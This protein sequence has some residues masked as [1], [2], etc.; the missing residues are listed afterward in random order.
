MFIT[1]FFVLLDC[2]YDL[3]DISLPKYNFRPGHSPNYSELD[4]TMSTV[5]RK[6]QSEG[7]QSEDENKLLA[8]KEFMIKLHKAK[9]WDLLPSQSGKKALH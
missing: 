8:M 3:I 9:G 2:N 1:L 5:F 7:M 6:L 4:N